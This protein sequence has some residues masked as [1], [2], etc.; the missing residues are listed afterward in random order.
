MVLETDMAEKQIPRVHTQIPC[1]CI[2]RIMIL[3]MLFSNVFACFLFK[4]LIFKNSFL[5]EQ[6]CLCPLV[7]I[8]NLW[9]Q[10]NQS[11]AGNAKLFFPLFSHG[12]SQYCLLSSLLWRHKNFAQSGKDQANGTSQ[13]VSGQRSFLQLLPCQDEQRESD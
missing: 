9:N 5:K 12:K 8:T 13:Y 6:N 11:R 4:F 3:L 10:G 7:V 2:P 1:E